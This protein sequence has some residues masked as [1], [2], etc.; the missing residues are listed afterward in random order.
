MNKLISAPSPQLKREHIFSVRLTS[1]ERNAINQLAKQMN[2]SPSHLV[3]HFL[4]QAIDY[5]STNNEGDS[6]N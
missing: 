3:R 6:V 5:Y 1:V 4:M 2:V